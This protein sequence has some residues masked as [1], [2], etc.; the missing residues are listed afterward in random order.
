[1]QATPLAVQTPPLQ[2][3]CVLAPHMAVP[4]TQPELVQVPP[5]SVAGHAEPAIT[6]FVPPPPSGVQQPPALHAF[7]AQQDW[8]VP[9]HCTHLPT[10]HNKPPAQVRAAQ[11]S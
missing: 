8:L 2:H 7:A 4:L 3:G 6:Q 5:P 9:P 10:A 11:H 1:M